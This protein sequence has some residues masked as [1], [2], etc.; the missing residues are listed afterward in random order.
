MTGRAVTAGF[1]VAMATAL[2]GLG[3]ASADTIDWVTWSNTF[4][5]NPAVG[6]ATGITSNGIVA[7]Y[8]GVV[9]SVQPNYP[10]WMPNSSYVGGVVGNAPPQSG[11]IVQ[12][13]GGNPNVV[14]T[15]TFSTPVTDPIFAIWSLG[16]GG[17]TASFD[18]LNAVPVI[19]AGGPS[20]EY[21]GSTIVTGTNACTSPDVCGAEG[22]GTIEFLGT[23][24]SISWTNPTQEFWYG[25][26][27]GVAQTP[28]PSTWTM[29]IAGFMGLGFLSYMGSRKRS[30]A[31]AA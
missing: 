31:L 10:S 5:A 20:A 23:F 7:G 16:Q 24:Q 12:I 1:V 28:L 19:V 14:D 27:V 11:G 6:T 25:F 22:N 29:L 15:V 17:L 18:F 4:T 30:L 8:L 26:T 13:Q 2:S 21:Q 9:I 3:S